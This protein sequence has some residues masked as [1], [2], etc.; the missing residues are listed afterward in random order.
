MMK[1]M[2]RRIALRSIATIAAAA[3]IAGIAAFGAGP[4]LAQPKE[5]KVAVAV[6]L[7]GPWA[8]NGELHLKGAQLA[9]EDINAEGGIKALGGAKMKLIVV[10]SGDSAEKA[11]NAAQR[12]LS[13][14]PDLVGGTGAFVS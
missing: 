11:K 12:M 14:D 1:Q 5:V 7:S 4:V 9:V 13:Q 6:P 3:G 8:R 10:D 2:T